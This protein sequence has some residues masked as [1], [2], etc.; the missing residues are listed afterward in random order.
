[1]LPHAT[2]TN[3]SASVSRVD[4]Q[5]REQAIGDSKHPPRQPTTSEP[6]GRADRRRRGKRQLCLVPAPIGRSSRTQL[7]VRDAPALPE[8]ARA[9]HRPRHEP[10]K[11]LPGRDD[12]RPFV[13]SESLRQPVRRRPEL[14]DR[15]RAVSVP[16]MLLRPRPSRRKVHPQARDPDHMAS[17]RRHGAARCDSQHARRRCTHARST[18]T[19]R[20]GRR[21]TARVWK[22]CKPDQP[23][24][25]NHT[26]QPPRR[27]P[28]TAT[29]DR[30]AEAGRPCARTARRA[31]SRWDTLT[32][33]AHHLVA[34]RMTRLS[35]CGS[36]R[37]RAGDL[38]GDPVRTT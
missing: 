1:M 24:H 15:V 28:E 27:V 21:S 16:T 31:H 32:P 14:D 20:D 6:R 23:A 2:Q 25:R 11:H 3:S 17:G 13:R 36:R 10:D 34:A 19:A 22:P 12:Q 18:G 8:R 5:A 30:S 4:E 33:S 7:R 35:A 26:E 29:T 38:V 37:G 9:S